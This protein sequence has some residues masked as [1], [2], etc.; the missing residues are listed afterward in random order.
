MDNEKRKILVVD[1][2]ST[3]SFLLESLFRDEGFEVFTAFSGKKA[4]EIVLKD[5]PN[6]ILLDIM[7]PGMTG[8]D[9]LEALGKNED[10]KKIPVIMVTAKSKAEEFDKVIKLGAVD[11]IQKPIDINLLIEKV[12]KLVA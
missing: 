3:N 10:T 4:I 9:V 6:V 2:S 8:Y 7:M 5:S 1:D 11:Y 12:K